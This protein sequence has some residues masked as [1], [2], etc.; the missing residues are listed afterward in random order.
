MKS[1]TIRGTP[2][3]TS[4]KN[5]LNLL[6]MKRS[7]C[8]PSAS[9]MPKGIDSTMPEMPITKARR[10]PPISS[11]GTNSMPIGMALARPWVSGAAANSQNRIGTRIAAIVAARVP[12]AGDPYFSAAQPM[13]KPRPTTIGPQI[14]PPQMR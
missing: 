13:T 12:M 11:E 8:R 4:M 5:T 9:A 2:R 6:M 1:H 7:D 14:E 10:K 3:M